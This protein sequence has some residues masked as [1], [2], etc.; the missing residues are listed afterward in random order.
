[1]VVSI[2][3]D[4]QL[5]RGRLGA[6]LEG[7]GGVTSDFMGRTWL[8]RKWMRWPHQQAP[9]WRRAWET[10]LGNQQSGGSLHLCNLGSQL[11]G[12]GVG[13]GGIG[14]YRI[15]VLCLKGNLH[16]IAPAFTGLLLMPTFIVLLMH[17]VPTMIWKITPYMCA[18]MLHFS[19]SE[20]MPLGLFKELPGASERD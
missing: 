10:C 2:Q 1:M 5:A 11:Q 4:V 13:W 3:G 15:S 18:D 14:A 12:V 8:P 19:G 20:G 7:R 16:R 6:R 17:N 9:S